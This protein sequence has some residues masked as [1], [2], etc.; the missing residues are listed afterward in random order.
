MFDYKNLFSFEE[1]DVEVDYVHITNI[2][3]KLEQ[4]TTDCVKYA[5]FNLKKNKNLLPWY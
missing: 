4:T 3:L 1:M 2:N 5:I